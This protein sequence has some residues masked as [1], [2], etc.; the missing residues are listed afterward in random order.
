M[1]QLGGD[2]LNREQDRVVERRHPILNIIRRRSCQFFMIDGMG[3]V[4]RGHHP[5][6]SSHLTDEESE[7]HRGGRAEAKTFAF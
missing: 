5:V 3:A 2:G 6:P 7:A 4:R 1:I